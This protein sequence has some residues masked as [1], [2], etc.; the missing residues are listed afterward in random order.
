M[1]CLDVWSRSDGAHQVAQTGFFRRLPVEDHVHLFAI[2]LLHC[3]QSV[4][5][6][7]LIQ[8]CLET[9]RVHVIRAP[10]QMVAALFCYE[11]HLT[12]I[13]SVQYGYENQTKIEI[14]VLSILEHSR[15]QKARSTRADLEFH[16]DREIKAGLV[17]VETHEVQEHFSK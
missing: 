15:I 4:L 12:Q 13:H 3:I 17:I 2:C 11:A 8:A 9:L 1:H 6:A 7:D 5:V 10:C 14:E 16:S